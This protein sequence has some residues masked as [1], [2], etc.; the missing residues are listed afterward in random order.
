MGEGRD[1]EGEARS[2]G[3]PIR[4]GPEDEHELHRLLELL[5]YESLNVRPRLLIAGGAEVDLDEQQFLRMAGA[6]TSA[7]D[8]PEG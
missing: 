8:E 5:P 1:P 3:Q 4:G 7:V 6:K 2:E